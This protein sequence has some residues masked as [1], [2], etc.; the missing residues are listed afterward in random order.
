MKLVME[1]RAA[2][3]EVIYSQ[4]LSTT[5]FAEQVKGKVRE[6]EARL[7]VNYRCVACNQ[8]PK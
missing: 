5:N 8:P 3:D 6:V 1:Y 4:I 2:R 7:V